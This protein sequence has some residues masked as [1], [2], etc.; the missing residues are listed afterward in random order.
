MKKN[1]KGEWIVY[2]VWEIPNQASTLY[3]LRAV[4]TSNKRALLY[5]E[6]LERDLLSILNGKAYIFIEEILLNHLYAY[7]MIDTVM[8]SKR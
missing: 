2:A 3:N 7:S 1:I 5:K 4:S 8:Q 6:M